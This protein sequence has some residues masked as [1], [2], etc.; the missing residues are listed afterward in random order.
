MK[1]SLLCICLFLCLSGCTH[2]FANEEV[3]YD[4]LVEHCR[5]DQVN[6]IS[7]TLSK[8]LNERSNQ[9]KIVSDIKNQLEKQL[10]QICLQKETIDKEYDEIKAQGSL[11]L[12]RLQTRYPFSYD[13]LIDAYI[14]YAYDTE[15]I[16]ELK[17]QIE[18]KS[19]MDS[20]YTKI[21]H[22]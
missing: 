19:E 15:F 2:A 16:N 14:K 9:L 1:L 4:T 12:M 21:S 8:E 7:L 10:K 22:R 18:R 17:E 3:D 6:E 11:C 20:E 5:L 13:S